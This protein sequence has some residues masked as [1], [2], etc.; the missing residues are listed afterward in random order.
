MKYQCFV[1]NWHFLTYNYK[2]AEPVPSVARNLAPTL[3]AP[4]SKNKGITS[5]LRLRSQP[6]ALLIPRNLK[7]AYSVIAR[8]QSDR[9]NLIIL[10]SPT[11]LRSLSRARLLHFVRNDKRGTSLAMTSGRLF[12]YQI[13]IGSK[14]SARRRHF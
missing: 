13:I 9:G 8:E 4:P 1:K 10:I 3:Q 11:R 6:F 5:L 2:I 7:N 12:F 14:I